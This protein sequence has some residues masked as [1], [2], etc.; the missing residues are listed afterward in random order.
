[1]A[2]R[3]DELQRRHF[4]Q[5][6]GKGGGQALGQRGDRD[7][8]AP[9]LDAADRVF[10]VAGVQLDLDAR[11]APP[12]A[13]QD[14]EQEAVAGRDR[15]VQ[16]DLA[17]QRAGFLGQALAQCIPVAQRAA[18]VVEKGVAGAGQFDAA[19]VALEQRG[20]DLGLEALD[21]AAERRGA[22]VAEFG[23]AAEMQALG[24]GDEVLQG[25]RVHS[26]SIA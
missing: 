16:A 9:G 8:L 25:A 3:D 11:V 13:R 23:G 5:A 10:R 7:V 6:K 2:V 26:P 19:V 20:A 15:A 1:M 4:D 18:R 17:V 21:A 12:H 22:D 14:V 24:Q